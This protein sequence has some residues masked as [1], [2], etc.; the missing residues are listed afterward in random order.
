[1]AAASCWTLRLA[2]DMTMPSDAAFVLEVILTNMSR[3][4]DIIIQYG[5]N[6]YPSKMSLAHGFLLEQFLFAGPL[7]K[8]Y[9]LGGG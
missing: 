5:C 1:M 6:Q 7:Y 9:F 4:R 3:Q 8:F 2:L